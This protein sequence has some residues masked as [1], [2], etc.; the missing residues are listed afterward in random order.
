MRRDEQEGPEA[1]KQVAEWKNWV[2]WFAQMP[3][4]IAIPYYAMRAI[5]PI[6]EPAAASP[7][8]AE[9]DFW[10]ACEWLIHAAD[11]VLDYL[12]KCRA[13]PEEEGAV[14]R[15]PRMGDLCRETVSDPFSMERWEWWKRRLAEL[16]APDDVDAETKQRVAKAIASMEA[17]EAEY[18]AEDGR[19][20]AE[21]KDEEK[22][23]EKD[24]GNDRART[25]ATV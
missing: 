20:K 17:A 8:E 2:S 13:L 25:N 12:M 22:G 9:C 1:C 15:A 6:E 3:K 23:R 16:A 5:E 14:G 11:T 21:K 7:T 18:G 19:E 4:D 24:E 10:T